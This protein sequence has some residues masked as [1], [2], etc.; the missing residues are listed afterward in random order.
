ML[1]VQSF[2]AA[3]RNLNHNGRLPPALRVPAELR[4]RLVAAPE[5][6][7]AVSNFMVPHTLCE[8]AC[9]SAARSSEH[10][11]TDPG[12][13]KTGLLE[14]AS[15]ISLCGFEPHRGVFRGHSLPDRATPYD[16]RPA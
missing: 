13:S 8:F 14:R 10:R 7:Q 1:H 4:L 15:P 9:R 5:L 11:S 16:T 12:A 3:S 2:R 6:P